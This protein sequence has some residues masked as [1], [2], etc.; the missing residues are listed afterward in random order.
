[1]QCTTDDS[2][3]HHV[4][5]LHE[6]AHLNRRSSPLRP[7]PHQG[8][9]CSATSTARHLPQGRRSRA[10]PNRRKQWRELV[11]SPAQDHLVGG[12]HRFIATPLQRQ[13]PAAASRRQLSP[14]IERPR[15]GE[16]GGRS[17]QKLRSDSS[18]HLCV[19]K[20]R[21]S[22]RARW[23][24][25]Q[26]PVPCRVRRRVPRRARVA[27]LRVESRDGEFCRGPL[28]PRPRESGWPPAGCRAGVRSE[29]DRAEPAEVVVG[30]FAANFCSACVREAEVGPLL[31]PGVDDLSRDLRPTVVGVLSRDRRASHADRPPYG[32]RRERAI[33]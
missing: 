18:R 17:K 33:R 6:L 12:R 9:L 1:M 23:S 13:D 4:L 3:N 21:L 22:G 14:R 31:D 25:R 8:Q 29:T 24:R 28:N 16:R 20:G 26:A 27:K 10:N 30:D 7:V 5:M 19:R 11:E 2:R 15:D 32:S